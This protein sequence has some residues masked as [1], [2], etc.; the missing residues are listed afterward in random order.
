MVQK[1]FRLVS[2]WF[3]PCHCHKCKV[4]FDPMREFQA[5]GLEF[6]DFND[7][8]AELRDLVLAEVPVSMF[9]AKLY[10]ELNLIE[11]LNKPEMLACD[12]KGKPYVYR[13]ATSEQGVHGSGTADKAKHE[14]V[15]K[16]IEKLLNKAFLKVVPDKDSKA[17]RDSF[18]AN[19]K[20]RPGVPFTATSKQLAA[21][22]CMKKINVPAL[23]LTDDDK[24]REWALKAVN[25]V[26][27]EKSAGYD[28]AVDGCHS[29][30]EFLREH[31]EDVVQCVVAMHFHWCRRRPYDRQGFVPGWVGTPVQTAINDELHEPRKIYE[32]PGGIPDLSKPLAL[33]RWRG[34]LVQGTVEHISNAVLTKV[35]TQTYVDRLQQGHATTVEG[36]RDIVDVGSSVGFS[37]NDGG[38][39]K[40][41]DIIR[42]M[43]KLSHTGMVNSSDIS[44]V[45]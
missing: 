39:K 27:L 38:V 37:S 34:I 12:K 31:Q 5:A 44:G 17:I 18:I 42:G 2:D 22:D 25:A 24:I 6:E 16:K 26:D 32:C 29:K 15:T 7:R 13:A 40:M 21:M 30:Q 36:V 28:G 9:E 33:R 8:F 23:D 11:P 3:P 10:I 1:N 35:F 45:D 41:C 4:I 43:E 20:R 14:R 19:V